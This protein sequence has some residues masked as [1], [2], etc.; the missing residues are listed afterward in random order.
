MEGDR[1]GRGEKNGE[2]ESTSAFAGFPA[3]LQAGAA[4]DVRLFPNCGLPAFAWLSPTHIR[5]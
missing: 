4:F 5:V 2:A 3:S 1:M